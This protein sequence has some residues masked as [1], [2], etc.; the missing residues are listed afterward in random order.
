VTFASLLIPW[1]QIWLEAGREGQVFTYANSAQTPAGIGD[2]VRVRLQGRPHTGLVV[3]WLDQ[4]PASLSRKT[5]Q[6]ILEVWQRAAVDPDWQN[7]MERVATE[8]HTSLF[9]TLKSALPPG[10][11]GQRSQGPTRPSRAIWLVERSDA[12]LPS[13]PLTERQQQLLMHLECHNGP[14][15]LRDLCGE[16]GFSRAV[17]KGLEARGL[18]RRL[19]APPGVGGAGLPPDH[20]PALTEAQAAAVQALAGAP[21]GQEFLLWGVTGAGKTE[22]YLQ[23]AARAL[24]AGQGAL[25]LTPEIGLIPQLLDRARKRFGCRVVEFHSGLSDGARVA[26]WRRCLEA[27]AAVV[28]GTRS[29]IFLPMPRLGLIVL[30]EEHDS[31]YK[32]DSPMPCYHAREVARLRARSS[33]A[34]LLLGSATPSLESWLN[35]QG[36]HAPTR[37]LRLP[38]R[39]GSRPLPAVRVIDMR[40]ELADGHRRLI[41]RALMGRLEQLQEK[42][43]QAVVLVPR[44]G[45]RAF[46]SCRSCGEAVLCPHCD[47][48][49]T[50]HRSQG[51]REWLRCHWCD[52][53]AELGDRCGHCGSKAFKPFGAGTQRVMEQ[54]ATELEGLRLLRFDRDTTRGRDGHR[55]L[56]DRFAQGEADVLVGTQMLAKGMDLPR[57]TL[58]AVLAADG[59][60]HRPDLR[61]SEQCLQL[62]LQLAGRAGRGEKPGE[63]LVQTYSPDHP[64]IRHLVDGRYELFLTEESQLRRQGGL[65]PFSR[66]CLLR[67]SGPSASGTAT[68][69]AALAER[70]RGQVEAA[71][72][73]LIGPAPAPVARV[74]GKCRWQLLLHGPTG[75]ALPLPSESL[76]RQGLAPG[77]GLAIDPDPINL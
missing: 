76:L 10:W 57:V 25:L 15:P 27:E 21:P 18:V 11:L 8:C 66:A 41:S 52:H 2:L 42:G 26:A 3:G 29:A 32:Q 77:V 56:L 47:V 23:A 49:L 48:A 35:C 12:A 62:L 20:W 63:V 65:V 9:K 58:A 4:L 45:Y 64:V 31:S 13:Q 1:L 68:A 34:L 43:E 22:V 6:P 74:A 24:D 19:Q 75:Q 7:L 14:M 60:L 46:L 51:G 5:I 39:I 69:A 54:L 17:L 16:G 61:S 67:L 70:I 73:L 30:D 55:R 40:H 28:V 53:R 72:W 33:G 50:V 71:G 59:L 37:L 44:R 38:E 36:P